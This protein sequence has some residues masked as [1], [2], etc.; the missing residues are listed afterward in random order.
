MTVTIPIPRRINNHERKVWNFYSMSHSL[1][2]RSCPELI[3]TL[4]MSED[5]QHNEASGA[6]AMTSSC[7]FFSPCPI[8]KIKIKLEKEK[9]RC[10]GAKKPCPS[11][12]PPVIVIGFST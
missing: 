9:Q 2:S 8:D 10:A 12:S 5:E 1:S 6:T 7:P 11:P 4:D 3:Y